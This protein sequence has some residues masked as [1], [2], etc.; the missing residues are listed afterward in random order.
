MKTTK[1][2]FLALV[3]VLLASSCSFSSYPEVCS[4]YNFNHGTAKG[5]KSQLKYTRHKHN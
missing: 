3:V 1:T 5:Q 4:A 2:I